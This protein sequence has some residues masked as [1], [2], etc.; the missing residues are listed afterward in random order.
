MDIDN[1]YD[2]YFELGSTDFYTTDLGGKYINFSAGKLV[3]IRKDKIDGSY[4]ES[5]FTYPYSCDVYFDPQTG[6]R[7]DSNNVERYS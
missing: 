3:A 4:V 5:K 2:V 1:I 6:E 7:I